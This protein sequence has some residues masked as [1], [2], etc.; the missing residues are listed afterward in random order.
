MSD[1]ISSSTAK[2]LTSDQYINM[3]L[4]ILG[5]RQVNPTGGY[6]SPRGKPPPPRRKPFVGSYP[7]VEG[8]PLTGNYQN[9]GQIP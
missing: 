3:I 7:M 6:N 9:Y 8:K 4:S 5:N 2:G 1:G